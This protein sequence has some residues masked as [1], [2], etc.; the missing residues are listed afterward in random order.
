[1]AEAADIEKTTSPHVGTMEKQVVSTAEADEALKF[2]RRE[3]ERGTFN[4][5]DE[6]KLV[7]KIDWMVVPV[8][9]NSPSF[10][11]LF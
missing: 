1:M 2:L 4:D 6:K 8:S 10:T 7:R 11:G 5:L 9:N 3:D